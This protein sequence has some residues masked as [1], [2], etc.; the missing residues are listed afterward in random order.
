MNTDLFTLA[1][2]GFISHDELEDAILVSILTPADA[3]RIRAEKYGRLDIDEWTEKECLT[4]FRFSK[5]DSEI[6]VN[7]LNIPYKIIT[8]D[9]HS[10]TGMFECYKR[11]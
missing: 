7:L 1:A 2:A 5:N 8:P 9:R 6:L 3:P 11:I 10:T 4:L